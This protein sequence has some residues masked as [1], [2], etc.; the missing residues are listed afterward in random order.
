MF[1]LFNVITMLPDEALSGIVRRIL[2]EDGF[3]VAQTF[4][5]DELF[6][7]LRDLPLPNAVLVD[8]DPHRNPAR[9]NKWSGLGVLG[10]MNYHSA[11]FT[12]GRVAFTRDPYSHRGVKQL[13]D[14]PATPH[15]VIRDTFDIGDLSRVM[16]SAIRIG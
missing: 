12:V 4:S 10:Y 8:I 5:P 16:H 7:K 1:E 9:N 13:L 3:A 2:R 14:T 15:G 6:D 11:L